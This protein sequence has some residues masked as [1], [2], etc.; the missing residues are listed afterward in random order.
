VTRL[1]PLLGLLP[2]LTNSSLAQSTT[3][4]LC[5]PDKASGFAYNRSSHQWE[6]AQFNVTGIKHILK[7]DTKGWIWIDFGRPSWPPLAYCEGPSENGFISCRGG[8]IVDFNIKNLRYLS[9]FTGGYVY[10]NL[11]PYTDEGA[12]TPNIEIGTCS[13]L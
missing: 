2:L 12:D 7:K 3:S 10:G 1:L 4:Y 13:L 6:S 8:Y 11:P 5:I 9:V